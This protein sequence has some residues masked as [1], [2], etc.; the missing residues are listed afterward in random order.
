MSP[1]PEVSRYEDTLLD[2]LAHA[3]HVDRLARLVGA[4]ADDGLDVPAVLADRCDDVGSTAA[5][6]RD[7]LLGEVL[8]GR[9][10]LERSGVD[11][12]VGVA[13]RTHDVAVVADVADA[14]LQHP[15]EVGVDRLV[16]GHRAMEV[17]Q[18]HR[19]LLGFVARQDDHLARGAELT[20]EQP[21]HQHLAER[22][23]AAGHEN[24][25]VVEYHVI[26]SLSR[27]RSASS[28]SISSQLGGDVAGRLAQPVAAQAAVD[29]D[30]VVGHHVQVVTTELAGQPAQ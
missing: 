27:M 7:R 23:G 6:G 14:K 28:A 30:L 13:D 9:Y 22:A 2:G 29:S 4:H 16:R 3:H 11:D 5:V 21:P 24:P 25:L 20:A 18:P 15:L 8:A 1:R 17:R 26:F 12:D 10:L 19:V